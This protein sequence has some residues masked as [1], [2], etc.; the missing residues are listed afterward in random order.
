MQK[1]DHK[2]IASKCTKLGIWGEQQ[3]GLYLSDKGFE[4]VI[5]DYR[6]GRAQV[7][8]IVRKPDL[9]VFVEVKTRSSILYGF[10]EQAVSDRQ[11]NLIL[12]A[13]QAW[14]IEHNWHG[15]IR[16]DILAIHINAV[17]KDFSIDHFEDAF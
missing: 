12:Q 8:L 13:A 15:M 4:M 2:F 6:S 10:A 1:K 3:A 16:F 17:S 11:K 9:I 14:M 7:D 5:S